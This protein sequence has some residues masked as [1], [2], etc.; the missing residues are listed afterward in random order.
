MS[1]AIQAAMRVSNFLKD[2]AVSAAIGR[3]ERRYFE[4]F[5]KAESSEARVRAWSKANLLDDF[6]NEMQIVID[7]GELAV[8]EAART[9]PKPPKE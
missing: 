5:K 2:E 8:L 1:A 9:A 3:L 4:E 6:L 7:T